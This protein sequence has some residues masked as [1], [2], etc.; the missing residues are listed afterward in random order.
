MVTYVI[1]TDIL[2]FPKYLRPHP[3]QKSNFERLITLIQYIIV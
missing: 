1:Y 2:K 3:Q